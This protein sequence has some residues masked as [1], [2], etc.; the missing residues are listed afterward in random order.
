MSDRQKR[1]T[2]AKTGGACSRGQGQSRNW[3]K[4]ENK[5]QISIKFSKTN[6]LSRR[7]INHIKEMDVLTSYKDGSSVGLEGIGTGS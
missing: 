7:T 4:G 3:Q 6:I 2:L 5:Q 1:L